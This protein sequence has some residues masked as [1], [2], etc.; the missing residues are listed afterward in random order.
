M[1]KKL[2]LIIISISY[3][4][5]ISLQEAY[6]EANSYQEY[7][8][9]LFLDSNI[10]YTG[11]LGIYEGNVFINCN[12]AIID[13]QEG[14]GIWLYADEEYNSS[15]DIQHCSIVNGLY[16]GLSF[17]GIS[18][19]NIYNCNFHST[20]FGLKLFDESSVYITNS[21][22]INQQSMGIGIYTE[23]PDITADYLLFWNN[24]DDCLEN[25]PGW[26]NI[27][28]QLELIPGSGILYENP[29]F[30]DAEHFNFN[31]IE[32]S[33]CINSGN[34]IILDDDGSISDLGAIIYTNNECNLSGDLNGD[35]ILDV[36][37][38]V[39]SVCIAMNPFYCESDC[40]GD[41]NN[42]GVVNVLDIV[43]MVNIILS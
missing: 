25:C 9:Y 29:L 39:S 26:G 2:L 42:D 15:L 31:L 36:L 20:N 7:D 8:K 6:D 38:I 4:L 16:Y 19:G 35:G 18:T 24:E 34:P 43:I 21:I 33:P 10:T 30:I 23:L 41:M 28:T 40:S 1:F 17:G 32:N 13:L 3:L 37:D 11:G 27:W 5:S 22:F 14:Q 12:G